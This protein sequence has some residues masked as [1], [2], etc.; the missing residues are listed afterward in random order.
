MSQNWR[1]LDQ[2][3]YFSKNSDEITQQSKNQTTL[4]NNL[5]TFP[6][7]NS[8]TNLLS[9]FTK[10]TW[11]SSFLTISRND[12]IRDRKNFLKNILE[13]CIKLYPND[14]D[15]LVTYLALEFHLDPKR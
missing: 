10:D 7:H 4:F 1:N 9:L 15:F 8:I 3:S 12:K 6:F 14:N 11:R 2:L 13:W 5:P